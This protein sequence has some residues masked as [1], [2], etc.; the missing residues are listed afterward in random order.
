MGES[1]EA[2]M[3][4]LSRSVLSFHPTSFTNFPQFIENRFPLFPQ[5]ESPRKEH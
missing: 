4:K 5:D 3:R 2:M 1:G